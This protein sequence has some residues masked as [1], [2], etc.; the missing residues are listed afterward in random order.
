M[1][2]G[3]L[4][5]AL[6]AAAACLVLAGPAFG[7]SDKDSAQAEKDKA[8]PAERGW[9]TGARRFAGDD[10]P[11]RPR[12]GR[13]YQEPAFARGYGDGYMNGQSDGRDRDRYDPVRHKDYKQGDQ[14]YFN[15]YGSKDA[16]RNN[17]RAGFRQGYED[18]YR[19]ITR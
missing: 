1:G 9:T 19:N 16:Y 13:G 14:G 18:G 2:A 7:Q 12:A 10:R 4:T 15:A 6:A 11:G 17:Y 3:K 5:R 8:K